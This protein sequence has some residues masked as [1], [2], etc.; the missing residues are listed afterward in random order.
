MT[1]DLTQPTRQA[2]AAVARSAKG[3]VTGRLRTALLT[4]IW[5]GACRAVAAKSA[6]MTDHSLRAALKKTHVKQFYLSEL[7]VLKTSERARNV[8][9]LVDV[10]DNSS[11]SMS[12]VQAAR[13]LEQLS[14]EAESR[15]RSAFPQIPG[16]VINIINAPSHMP[17]PAT[18][19]D[20]EAVPDDAAE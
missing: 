2:R 15:P 5:E 10:R 18:T 14:E 12:R 17:Q 11:N 20:V 7:D 6:G 4:M 8:L 19:I 3:Q 13:S 16:L 9:A 1:T